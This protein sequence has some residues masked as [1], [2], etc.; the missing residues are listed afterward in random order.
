LVNHQLS[1]GRFPNGKVTMFKGL[2]YGT[3]TGLITTSAG[4]RY[5]REN[6]LD[7]IVVDPA[8]SQLHC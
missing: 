2:V 5:I 7:T 1:H 8:A 6:G 4:E 3:S